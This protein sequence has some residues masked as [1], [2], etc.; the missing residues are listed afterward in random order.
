M[1]T[2]NAIDRRFL[3]LEMEPLVIEL[4]KI[5]L[6]R[7]RRQFL[8]LA[9]RASEAV[10]TARCDQDDTVMER[11]LLCRRGDGVVQSIPAAFLADRAT[12]LNSIRGAMSLPVGRESAKVEVSV[13]GLMVKVSREQWSH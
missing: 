8:V 7:L 12:F 11:F 10:P 13:V 6:D 1:N 5:D 9:D 4:A 3:S 2:P